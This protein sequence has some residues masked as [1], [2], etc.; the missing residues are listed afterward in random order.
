MPKVEGR[1][2][3]QACIA[4]RGLDKDAFERHLAED[5]S[6]RYAIE[7]HTSREAERF[8]TGVRMLCP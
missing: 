1:A 2:E 5:F 4:S 7:C 3:R 6:I 8:G